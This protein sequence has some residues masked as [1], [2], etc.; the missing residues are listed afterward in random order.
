MV[1]L[2]ADDIQIYIGFKTESIKTI[3]KNLEN[4]IQSIQNWMQ[5]NFLKLNPSKTMIKLLKPKNSINGNIKSFNLKI[6]NTFIKLSESV[7]VLGVE[8]GAKLNFQEFI[9]NKIR[10]CNF[11][12]RNLKNIKL[13]LPQD[14]RILLINNLILSNLDYCN[15]ILACLPE[16][17]IYPLQK[18]LNKAV[19]FIFNL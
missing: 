17:Q 11:H 16:Y 10:T 4:C 1:S 5:E 6:G 9:T 3:E 15:S 19:R 2:Y 12:L 14:T 18:I 8:V 13:C 7:K